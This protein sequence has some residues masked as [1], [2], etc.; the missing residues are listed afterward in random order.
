MSL[1]SLRQEIPEFLN[2]GVAACSEVDPELFFPHEE[3]LPNG[4]IVAVYKNQK[5]AVEV[6]RSCS[7]ITDCLEYSLKNNEY[8]IWGGMNENQRRGL[9]QRTGI[10]L[11]R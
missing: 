7:L 5:Q 11:S 6:C 8:G 1:Q 10:K 2:E 4:R 3:E 9:R